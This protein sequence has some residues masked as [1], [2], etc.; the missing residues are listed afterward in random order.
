GGADGAAS[1]RGNSNYNSLQAGWK[2]STE[3]LTLTAS[4]TFSKSLADVASRGFQSSGQT[5]N[6]AQN[7]RDF[8]AEYGPVGFDRTH[9][10]T[11][12]YI[13][14]LPFLRNRKGFLGTA[15]GSWTFSGLTVI[16]SGFALSPGLSVS[17]P[18]LAS[19][20]NVVGAL[21]YPHT[22]DQWFSTGT[23]APAPWG[24]YG[25][26]GVGI[27]R[28][29]SEDVWNWALYKTF[30]LTERFKLQFRGEFFNIFNHASFGNVD[31]SVGSGTYGQ[32]T[33][34]LNPRILEFALRLNF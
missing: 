17:S 24:F 31:T 33:S 26:A 32:V 12:S 6:G 7:A 28:S 23:F 9:I 22:V 1:Y 27:I 20:P 5:G 10:F 11:S 8:Q 21:S 4:Y 14:E 13:Y 18:G 16:E 29:P 30:P 15:L 3:H 34:A 19:R 2:Y 25:N